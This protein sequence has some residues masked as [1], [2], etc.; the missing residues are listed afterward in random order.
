MTNVG[1]LGGGQ[2]AQMFAQAA[3]QIGVRVFCIERTSDAC[4]SLVAPVMVGDLSDVATL[5]KW[6]AENKI[7]VVTHESEFVDA[8]IACALKGCQ[9]HPSA[10][11]LAASQERLREK[12]IFADLGI[13]VPRFAGA[14]NS[15]QLFAAV[16]SIGMPCVVKT[17]TGGYDGKGQVI[18]QGPSDLKAAAALADARPV[19]IESFVKFDRELSVIAVRG[20]DG[21]VV[22][23]PIVENEHRSGILH[24]TLAPAL[25]LAPTISEQANSYVRRLLEHVGYVGALCLELFQVGDSVLGNEFAPR[26]HNSGH[27]TIGGSITSQF[28]NH[29]RAIS[30]LPLGSTE[31]RGHVGMVNLVGGS[32]EVR[33]LLSLD[34][35]QL[36]LYGK[37]SRPGRKIGHATVIADTAVERDKTIAKVEGLL[38]NVLDVSRTMQTQQ[39]QLAV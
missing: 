20:L 32:P 2:L 18:L 29:L 34:R 38:R 22:V 25:N 14:D 8:S 7:D 15:Q 11:G 23:Y 27:W 36:H 31:T 10:T 9:V 4:A 19:I 16:E 39:S 3:V 13:P 26:P 37:V 24:K 35:V 1:V 12:Q 6:V 17:R 5:N 21:E 30:N 28:E 33:A